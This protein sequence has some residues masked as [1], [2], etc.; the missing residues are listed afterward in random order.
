MQFLETSCRTGINVTDAFVSLI[1][2]IQGGTATPKPPTLT[3]AKKAGSEIPGRK[4]GLTAWLT[5]R[6]EIP[7]K[8][9]CSTCNKT[10]DNLLEEPLQKSQDLKVLD[11]FDIPRRFRAVLTLAHLLFYHDKE[12]R[13][14]IHL[15][16][17]CTIK[18]TQLKGKFALKLVTPMETLTLI[19]PGNMHNDIWRLLIQQAITHSTT[20][21]NPI[22]TAMNGISD[23]SLCQIPTR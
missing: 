11:S 22:I 21:F 7:G 16:T 12:C 18:Q 5:P 9:F 14:I 1:Q 15:N 10:L 2:Q 3:A 13:I 4:R 17:N 23:P 6:E 19:S 8:F 20:Q